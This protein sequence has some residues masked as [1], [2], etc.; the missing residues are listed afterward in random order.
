MFLLES[1]FL[2][3][4]QFDFEKSTR[5]DLNILPTKMNWILMH[6]LQMFGD[7][8][9]QN[10]ELVSVTYEELNYANHISLP[11]TTHHSSIRIEHKQ[12]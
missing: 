5:R 9:I 2:R 11:S 10:I 7:I 6:S 3:F 1:V 4:T 8:R 12:T